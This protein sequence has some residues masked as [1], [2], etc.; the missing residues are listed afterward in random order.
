MKKLL[1]LCALITGMAYG[2]ASFYANN[3]TV[4]ASNVPPGAQAAVLTLPFAIVTVCAYPNSGSP[5]TNTVP[6]YADQALTTPLTQ[7]ITADAQGR[8]QFW[9]PGGLYSATY[10]KPSGTVVGQ[11]PF[12][13]Q[14]V[15]NGVNLNPPAS[16]QVNQPAGTFFQL[17]NVSDLNN[18]HT[19]N[20]GVDTFDTFGTSI[21]F[22]FCSGCSGGRLTT[23]YPTT[24][25]SIMGWTNQNSGVS[26]SACEDVLFDAPLFW[27]E[28]ITTSSHTLL[29]HINNDASEL[30][31]KAYLVDFS[32]G[33]R[34][35][36]IAWRGTIDA[37]KVT[38]V[39]SGFTYTGSWSTVPVPSATP[40]GK[41]TTSVGAT[42]TASVTGSTV[43]FVGLKVVGNFATYGL[44]I[45]GVAV[46]DPITQ[47][48]SIGNGVDVGSALGNGASPYLIRV[49]GLQNTTHVV[50]QTC[51]TV[52]SPLVNDYCSVMWVQGV[53]RDNATKSGPNV[54]SI[55]AMRYAL[56]QQGCTPGVALCHDD[57][58]ADVYTNQE[59]ADVMEMAA[60]GVNVMDVN[61]S[62]I[63]IYDPN[64]STCGAQS[65]GI[66]PTQCAATL[67]GAYIAGKMTVNSTNHDKADTKVSGCTSYY[68]FFCGGLPSNTLGG[69]AST[70]LPP[71]GS[72]GSATGFYQ[73]NIYL[74]RDGII[75]LSRLSQF[76]Y[77][78]A[79][80]NNIAKIHFGIPGATTFGFCFTGGGNPSMSFTDGTLGTCNLATVIAKAAVFSTIQPSM[81]TAPTGSCSAFP[82]G[83]LAVALDG[84][85]SS[86]AG[87]TWA[88]RW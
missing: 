85:A 25:S 86:C 2:Q 69:T 71:W 51:L 64:S 3:V 50:R 78:F 55:T 21:E 4:S 26:S 75:G 77:G 84:H 5:C 37:N 57:Q 27:S 42:A 62:N 6:I 82:N 32:R 34:E 65:D 20:A 52:P 58:V 18:F 45:D 29:G 39:S 38:G 47:T 30:G 76:E 81:S 22:G 70:I 48:T 40:I 8:F 80:N 56:N 88:S 79:P 33:C 41:F 28:P 16:Q 66:H 53:G 68:G 10:Q 60:D 7:P 87:G 1:P 43:Y 17:N 9:A 15:F 31:I 19:Y 14:A 67:I 61:L 49:S 24:I 11:Y 36:Q 46:M 74:G 44:T 54:V 73:G 83:T 59:Q 12:A 63:A 35:A 23:P 13:I 72:L